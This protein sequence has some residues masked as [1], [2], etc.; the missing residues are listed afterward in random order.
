MLSEGV[1]QLLTWGHFADAYHAT[2][3]ALPDA[4]IVV[5]R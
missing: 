5:E 3:C 1:N 2:F 4:R